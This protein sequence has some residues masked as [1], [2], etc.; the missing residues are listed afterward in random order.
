MLQ[1][2]IGALGV[3]LDRGL[4][5]IKAQL[6]AYQRQAI[7]ELRIYGKEAGAVAG[8]I[9][10]GAIFALLAVMVALAALFLFVERHQGTYAALGVIGLATALP[11]AVLFVL[12]YQR[13]V[14]SG[15]VAAIAVEAPARVVAAAG[16]F[17]PARANAALAVDAAIDRA[18]DIVRSGSRS[19]LLGTLA[20]TAVVG[21]LYGRQRKR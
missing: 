8:L 15:E 18:E 14:R 13:S 3:D 6:D 7:G 9:I 16:N 10:A 17:P 20:L 2:I 4:G 19:A 21:V 11:A 12:A 5:R 1:A